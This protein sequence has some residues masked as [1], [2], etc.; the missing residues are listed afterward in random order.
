MLIFLFFNFFKNFL[1]EG[2]LL[3]DF[4]DP[5]KFD[6]VGFVHIGEHKLQSTGLASPFQYRKFIIP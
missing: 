3:H 5:W 6:P 4:D 2:V 1:Q